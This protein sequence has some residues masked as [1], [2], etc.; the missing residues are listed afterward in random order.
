MEVANRHVQTHLSSAV[1]VATRQPSTACRFGCGEAVSAR[2]RG[3]FAAAAG[4]EV[5]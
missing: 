1:A 4:D 3:A 2:M 5:A